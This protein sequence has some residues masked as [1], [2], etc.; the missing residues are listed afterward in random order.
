MFSCDTSSTSS[1]HWNF[2]SNNSVCEKSKGLESSPCKGEMKKLGIQSIFDEPTAEAKHSLFGPGFNT[3]TKE[4][5][6]DA[7]RTA[8][9]SGLARQPST[10]PYPEHIDDIFDSVSESDT[11][12]KGAPANG[13][14]SS[15]TT[16]TTTTTTTTSTL[17]N[18]SLSSASKP[19]NLF[20]IRNM[21]PQSKKAFSLVMEKMGAQCNMMYNE[22]KQCWEER[23]SDS[24]SMKL[25]ISASGM[26][27]LDSC[28]QQDLLA[29]S[30]RI[31]KS[32]EETNIP[33]FNSEKSYMIEE[34]QDDI[35]FD[36]RDY[37]DFGS[38]IVHAINDRNGL[39]SS[40]AALYD[41]APQLGGL[42]GEPRLS[43]DLPNE[44]G[45]GDVLD[46]APSGISFLNELDNAM[47]SLAQITVP[48]ITL[49]ASNNS[50][51]QKHLH[52]AREEP[53]HEQLQHFALLQPHSQFQSSLSRED[54]QNSLV[55]IVN[56]EVSS[57]SKAVLQSILEARISPC[58][59]ASNATWTSLLELNLDDSNLFHL[60]SLSFF[61][62]N[63]LRLSINDNEVVY[64]DGAPSSLTTLIAKN[65]RLSN[66]TSLSHLT[67]LKFL[68]ISNNSLLDL[69]PLIPLR[70]LRELNVSGNCLTELRLEMGEFP[71][72]YS[73]DASRNQIGSIHIK[74]P[75][76]AKLQCLYIDQNE[77]SILHV[78]SKSLR[79]L[80]A[81]KNRLD[82]VQ[83]PGCINLLL[84][85]T[86]RSL[87]LG[88]NS[89]FRKNDAN[90]PDTIYPVGIEDLYMQGQ[91]TADEGRHSSGLKIALPLSSRH[92]SY[93]YLKTLTIS[94]VHLP[95]EF[96]SQ[97]TMYDNL[98]TL[99]AKRCQI[100]TIPEDFCLKLNHLKCL[101]LS[102]NK[103]E[104]IA[105]LH[106]LQS[107]KTLDLSYNRLHVFKSTI[108][109]ISKLRYL[110][111]LDLRY[112]PITARFYSAASDGVDGQFAKKDKQFKKGLDDVLFMKRLCYR[113]VLGQSSCLRMLDGLLFEPKE[114]EKG[115]LILTRNRKELN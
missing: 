96:M 113:S 3:A 112:N 76:L 5:L 41:A 7:V 106:N 40:E 80:H 20:E 78:Q 54:S 48:Q 103:I 56:S 69:T 100:D 99:V 35:S 63:I 14:P 28:K 84:C 29:S 92:D 32:D 57:Q 52:S 43:N 11:A 68:D 93:K 34:I 107:L 6:E 58:T 18:A 8:A 64:L 75:A 110:E 13:E 98:E 21:N 94:D 91:I 30:S 60:R 62:P 65:N 1:F 111:S 87:N 46:T 22:E 108:S 10:S 109:N 38:I 61:T 85:D 101:N 72:L 12:Q 9:S 44:E 74:E 49:D 95:S 31:I 2:G 115:L 66:L 45:R 27:S 25:S 50:A 16:T 37:T 55:S 42:V 47:D 97:L 82:S 4:L 23:R 51:N 79:K 77:I 90:E 36:Q 102:E 59:S 17:S 70:N 105:P 83:N 53:H 15:N 88:K 104:D 26:E 19:K 86:L 89:L 81:E 33:A 39:Q 71:S 73:L 114:R 24:D 67:H